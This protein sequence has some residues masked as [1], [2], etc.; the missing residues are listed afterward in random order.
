MWDVAAVCHRTNLLMVKAF[1]VGL[2][3]LD[4]QSFDQFVSKATPF[5]FFFFKP[6]S[7]KLFDNNY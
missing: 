4:I 7:A 3:N 6:P 5:F 2:S 1:S